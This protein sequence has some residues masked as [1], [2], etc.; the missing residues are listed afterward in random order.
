M[1]DRADYVS[2]HSIH[3]HLHRRIDWR[4]GIRRKRLTCYYAANRA[5]ACCKERKYL[6]A[7]RFDGVTSEKSLE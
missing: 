7:R 4:R 3:S 6:A 5:Q 2:G 1:A